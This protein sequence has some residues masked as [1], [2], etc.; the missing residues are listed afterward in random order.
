MAG[1]FVLK[2]GT[3]GKFHFNLLDPAAHR[4]RPVGGSR[5]I[6]GTRVA[7]LCGHGRVEPYEP[8]GVCLIE[9]GD[10]LS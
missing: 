4:A 1:K 6:V 9:F 2:K 7:L 3:T 5:V 10:G 8:Y